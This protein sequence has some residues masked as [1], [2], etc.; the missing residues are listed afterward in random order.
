MPHVTRRPERFEPDDRR[1]I[2]RYLNFVDPKRV[3]EVIR[4]V[5][6][7]PDDQLPAL[8]DGVMADFGSRHRDVPVIFLDHYER[9]AKA[10]PA[11]RDRLPESMKL[12]IG[13]YFT[14]EYSIEAAAL[15]NPSIVAAPDQTGLPPGHLR[16]IMS[17]RAT[18][19][20][21]VSSI[22]LHH[23]VLTAAGDIL[24]DSPPRY[25]YAAPAIA[26]RYLRKRKFV[27]RLL[28]SGVVLKDVRCIITALPNVFTLA[29]L[30]QIVADVQQ[31]RATTAAFRQAAA[32]MLW[33]ARANYRLYF[34]VDCP[35][36][37][38]VI[39]PAT[40]SESHG[41]EDLRLV[42]FVD[43]DGRAEYYGTYT[44]FDGMRTVPMLLGSDDFRSFEISTLGGRY[45]RDKGMALFPRKIAGHYMMISRHDRE[46]LYLLRSDDLLVW[47]RAQPLLSPTEPWELV[48]MG[49][50]GSPVE[51]EAGWILLTHAVGPVRR[52]CIGAAL[53]DRDDPGRVIGRLRLPLLEPTDDEREGY[54]PNVLY[55]CGSIIHQGQLLIPY[56]MADS[57][58]AFATVAVD[59]L[60]D[61]LLRAGP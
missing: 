52:Y 25:A 11:C 45:A 30:E 61:C 43:D 53:L 55:S 13:A 39:F 14:N 59:E 44:A 3:G 38:A 24:F 46:R 10:V 41:M 5:M 28:E 48:Q 35:V 36:G 15:F 34:P 50:C 49:N 29:H 4:R 27:R 18:G 22:V 42:R 54:V 8:L 51:T 7:I 37:E 57:R 12:L 6:A 40:E 56:A 17:L 60:V 58:T 21:H 9:A 31:S 47:D 19:E 2:M 20:G 1:V 26:D 33:R 23:G 32:D 16:F